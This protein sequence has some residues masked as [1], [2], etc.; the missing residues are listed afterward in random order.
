MTTVSPPFVYS[1]LPRNL[2]AGYGAAPVFSGE[3]GA[4]VSLCVV[5]RT[6]RKGAGESVLVALRETLDGHCVL[7]CL[8]DRSGRVLE[9]VEVWSQDPSGLTRAPAAYREALTNAALDARWSARCKAIE[10]AESFEGGGLIRTGF[11]EVSPG[12]IFVDS[13]KL[14]PLP[15]RDQRTGGTWTLC[16]DEALLAKKG[17]PAYSTTLARHLFQPE[18]GEQSDMLPVD[19]VGGDP[20]GLGL[21]SEAAAVNGAGGLMMVRRYAPLSLEQYLDAVSGVDGEAGDPE[22]LLSMIA[23]AS[24]GSRVAAGG[25]LTLGATDARSRL[26]EALHLKLMALAGAAAAVRT[27]VASTGTPL[28]NLTAQSFRVMMARGGVATPMLWSARPVLAEPGEAVELSLPGTNTSFY[29]PAKTGSVSI[30][31]PAGM[32]RATSGK[33]WMRL[34]NVIAGQGAGG[35]ASGGVILEGTLSTQERL[36]PGKGDLVW[37]RML[38]GPSRVDLYATLDAGTSLAAGEFRVRTLPTKLTPEVEARLQSALGVPI[39]DVTFDVVPQLST[40]CDLYALGVLGVRALLV[41]P[42]RPLPVVLDEVLSLASQAARDISSGADLPSRL[43]AVFES[44]ARWGE[45]LGPQHIVAVEKGGKPIGVDEGFA[46]V[47]PRLWMGCLAGI[48]RCLTGIGPDARCRDYG[49]AP[50]GGAHR[51]F[52]GLL[53]DLYAVLGSCRTLIVSDYTTTSEIRS[54]VAECLRSARG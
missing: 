28:L 39:P 33:G 29:M 23:A 2:P 12:V 3:V 50:Q 1:P 9:F 20:R 21:P 53:D 40:P 30:Y 35:N 14:S 13:K 44:D 25:W 52:D 26:V 46:A 43:L 6:D 48:I 18:M 8:R 38:M 32:M 49:D 42:G 5:V 19:M 10:E 4:M 17:A 31:A 11:E 51:V 41:G 7:G 37:L 36:A 54:V 16:T 34:R 27:H 47:P 15:P 24:L 22:G 45:M